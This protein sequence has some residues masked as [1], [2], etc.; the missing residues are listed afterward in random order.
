MGPTNK[1][2]LSDKSANFEMSCSPAAKG[3][4][5]ESDINARMRLAA[6]CIEEYRR[7]TAEQQQANDSNQ[8]EMARAAEILENCVHTIERLDNE[9]RRL[10]NER[11]ILGLLG[12]AVTNMTESIFFFL[13]R[14]CVAPVQWAARPFPKAIHIVRTAIIIGI[15]HVVR[16][17]DKITMVCRNILRIGRR[18]LKREKI[19]QRV[20]NRVRIRRSHR[21]KINVS[22][23]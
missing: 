11:T 7:I 18:V 3:E 13:W 5:Q 1:P 14:I 19:H 6:Q 8:E 12:D 16:L 10:R 17:W 20:P 22:I 15:S 9:V 2:Q 21:R 23:S 4:E